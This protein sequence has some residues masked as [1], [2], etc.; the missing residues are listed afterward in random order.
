MPGIILSKISALDPKYNKLKFLLEDQK[1]LVWEQLDNEFKLYEVSQITEINLD[2]DEGN[3][4]HKYKSMTDKIGHNQ[5]PL[6]WWNTMRKNI[7]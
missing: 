2:E 1:T 5:D 4:L 6:L 7:L 3:K